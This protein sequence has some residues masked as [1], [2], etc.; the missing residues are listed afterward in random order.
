MTD[1]NATLAPIAPRRGIRWGWI[2]TGFF[3][4]LAII[5]ASLF[6]APPA[7]FFTSLLKKAIH[8]Q[9]GRELTVTSSRYRIRET[10]TVELLGVEFGRPGSTAGTSPLSA[11]KVTATVPLRSLMDGTPQILSLDLDAPVFNLVRDAAG[12]GNWEAPPVPPAN[13]ETAQPTAL[14]LPPTTIRNGTLIYRDERDATDLRFDAIDATLAA[15]ATYGGA[16][17]KGSL[18]FKNEPIAF[19]LTA[20]DTEAALSGKT[21]ALTLALDSRILKARLAGEGA[22]GES[23]MLAGE[24]DASSPSARELAA[25]L[26]FADS[27][28]ATA[29]ALTLKTNIEPDTTATRATGRI[30]L[31][32]APIAY[33]VALASLR[34]IIAGKPAALKG[35]VAGEGLTADLDG[36]AEIAIRNRYRGTVRATAQSI[37]VLAARLG[38]SNPAVTALGPGSLNATIDAAADKLTLTGAEF[39]AGGRTGKFDGEIGL[40]GPRP[41]VTGALE[42]SKLDLDALLGRTPAPPTAAPESAPPDDG[43]ATTYDVLAAELDAIENPPPQA[44]TL[45]AAPSATGWSTAPIDL[46]ALRTVDLDLDLTLA[47]LKFGQLPLGKT[48]LKTKLE[49]GELAATIHEAVIGQG[50]GSGEIALKARGTAHDAA[51]GLKFVNVDAEP[52]TTELSGKPLLKGPSNVEISTRAN[53]RSLAE[54][55]STLDGSARIDMK[56]GQLRG[57]DI[58]A[59]VAELWNYKGWGYTPSRN[60]PVDQL[61]ANYTIKAGTVRSTP[62]LTMKGPTAGLRS[63]GNV[64]V[65]RRHIDQNVDVQNLFFNIVIKGDWTKKLWI[66]PAFLAGVQPAPGAAPEAGSPPPESALP[67]ALPADLVARIE[68]ILSDSSASARLSGAQKAFLTSLITGGGS[69]T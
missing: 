68:R 24:I 23:P 2:V 62:D 34:E 37:G 27:V 38:V 4:L 15:D 48:R 13:N 26:G 6:F 5:A 16:A 35:T 32:D 12:S 29:G 18:A 43:F 46:N 30:V 49:N 53:G 19:D 64:V 61:T 42:L 55:V 9:T 17:A 51:I 36:T 65:P 3:A 69:G 41:R 10:V 47:S 63:V 25:W 7:F 60:T 50:T 33:D 58:G 45:E 66:G 67:R 57:W 8:D 56:K 28:P 54:L 22:F 1:T 39:D 44:A 14:P 11:R 40:S 52:V 59:M 31:R 21:T 20:A